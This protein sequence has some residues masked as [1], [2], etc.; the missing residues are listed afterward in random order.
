MMFTENWFGISI[1]QFSQNQLQIFNF[2]IIVVVTFIITTISLTL[3]FKNYFSFLENSINL[4][5]I[6]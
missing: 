4:N 2:L 6:N 1:T 3:Q 5:Q